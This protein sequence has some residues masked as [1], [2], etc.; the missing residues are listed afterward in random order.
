MRLSQSP[1]LSSTTCT[2]GRPPAWSIGS[3][4][5]SGWRAHRKTEILPWRSRHGEGLTALPYQLPKR[6][7]RTSFVPAA[8][9][10]ARPYPAFA[11]RPTVYRMR[12]L[13]Y[14]AQTKLDRYLDAV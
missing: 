10:G 12:R 6:L 11:D 1:A 5:Q 13:A 2:N 4:K 9:L 7:T 3:Q 14:E 8:S